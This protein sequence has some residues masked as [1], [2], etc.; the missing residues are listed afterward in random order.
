MEQLS[1]HIN[2]YRERFPKRLFHDSC[3]LE[4]NGVV[5]RESVKTCCTKYPIELG[6][7]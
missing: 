3:T 4:T 5:N 2:V 1:Q 6:H 7:S